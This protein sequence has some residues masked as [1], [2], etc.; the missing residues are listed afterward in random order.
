MPCLR[1]QKSH[2]ET[3]HS[4]EAI[5]GANDEVSKLGKYEKL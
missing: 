3:T 4:P 5:I 2:R 1:I